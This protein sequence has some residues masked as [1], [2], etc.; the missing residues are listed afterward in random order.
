MKPEM[1]NLTIEKILRFEWGMLQNVAGK[2]GKADCQEDWQTFHIM[3][4]S[5]YH[6]WSDEMI[7]SY[8]RDMEEA[9]DAGRNLVMEK[10]AYMMEYTD[11]EYFKEK[12]L[13]HLPKI[14][15]ETRQMIKDIAEYLVSCDK[16][17]SMKYPK[18]S[19]KGR[20]IEASKDNATDT[21][22]ESYAK[23]ELST[24]TKYTLRLFLDYIKKC[25]ENGINFSFLVKDKMVKMYG[26][27]SIEDA[28]YKM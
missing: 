17:F 27:D 6:A 12:L 10:Y 4:Y 8:V 20:P 2:N 7:R 9:M 15:A 16:E 1:R 24:Y 3:R 19:R 28:E 25:K 14:D 13:L 21:S 23:G 5:Y 18:L 11:P 22:A 26:Y